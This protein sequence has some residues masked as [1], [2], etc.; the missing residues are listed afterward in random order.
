MENPCGFSAHTAPALVPQCTF[1]LHLRNLRRNVQPEPRCDR[2]LPVPGGWWL[3]VAVPFTVN[4]W[5]ETTLATKGYYGYS[6][7]SYIYISLSMFP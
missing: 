7:Y 1:Q 3:M 5:D 4:K 6:V 2:C